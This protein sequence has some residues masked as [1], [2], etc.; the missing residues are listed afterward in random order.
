M[1]NDEFGHAQGDRALQDAASILRFTLRSADAM[2]R[3][4]GDEFIVL[5]Q[6]DSEEALERLNERLQEGFDFFNATN[7]RPYTLAMSSGTA[8]CEPGTRC[9]LEELK[10]LADAQMYGEKLRRREA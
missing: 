9:R 10:S 3:V 4:G 2:A 1:I 5:A 8:W 6:G 7:Q